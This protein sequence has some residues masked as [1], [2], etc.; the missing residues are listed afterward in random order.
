MEM[1]IVTIGLMN[2]DVLLVE[3]VHCILTWF[4]MVDEVSVFNTEVL[5]STEI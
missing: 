5:T 1:Y 3:V 2:F 4:F